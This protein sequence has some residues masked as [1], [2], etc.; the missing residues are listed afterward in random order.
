MEDAIRIDANKR[1]LAEDNLHNQDLLFHE[2]VSARIASK[3]TVEDV[4]TCL[5]ITPSV[6]EALEDGRVELTLADLRQYAYAV[7]ALLS[8]RVRPNYV[9]ELTNLT[10]RIAGTSRE[11][12]N[13][14]AGSSWK[15]VTPA[16][17]ATRG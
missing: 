2:L 9:R 13:T 6:V 12:N 8:Y 17:I 10:Q 1:A 15:S 7:G 16:V 5:G 3:R 11:W 14:L 4:A